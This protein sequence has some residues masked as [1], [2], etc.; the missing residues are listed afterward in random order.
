[1][2]QIHK[3]ANRQPLTLLVTEDNAAGSFRL[4][5]DIFSAW[6]VEETVV[7][8]GGVPCVD[9]FCAAEGGVADE[10][11][12]AAV[13]GAR[14]EVSAVVVFFCP[15]EFVVGERGIVETAKE[16]QYMRIVV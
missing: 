1:M 7:D 13:V 16:T 11:V 8:A 10:G 5:N 3:L 6:V 4:T 15:V 2:S 9:A 12:A 14:G